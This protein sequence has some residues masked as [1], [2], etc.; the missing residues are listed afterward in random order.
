MGWFSDILDAGT[1][2]YGTYTAG[3]TPA[4]RQA[5]VASAPATNWALIGGIGAAVLLVIILVVSRK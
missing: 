4:V 3:Q 1:T 2:A 5:P